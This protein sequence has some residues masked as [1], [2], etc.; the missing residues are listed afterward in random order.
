[1]KPRFQIALV[2][3]LAGLCQSARGGTVVFFDP[4]QTAALVS[5]GVTSDT[6]ESSGYRFTYTRDKLFTGGTGHVIGRP[7]RVPWPQGVEAQAVTEGP[8][9]SGARL[10]ISRAD[11][12]LFDLTAFTAK[13]LANTAATG[14]SIEIMPKLNG[15][16][17]FNDPLYFDASGY[18]GQSFSYDESPWYLG[19][20]AL[21]KNF[22]S[23]NI[24]LFVDFALTGLTLFSAFD[25]ALVGDANG[26]CSVGAADYA[27]WAA[28]FGQTGA[29]LSADFDANGSVGAGDYTLWAANFGNTCPP[30]AGGASGVPEPSTVLLAALGFVLVPIL[31][32]A[33][34]AR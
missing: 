24:G 22:E 9:T 23:Y 11:G 19:S 17:A 3:A 32:R 7:V 26:D 29:S 2:F 27:I 21:L 8:S 4:L 5:E 31:R 28:Q 30:A 34:R 18:Y 20:T 16:D 13:L 14:A 10:N 15:E 12:Q 33:R 6:I 1:M 25:P